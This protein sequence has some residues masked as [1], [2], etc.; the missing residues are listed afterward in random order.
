MPER[1][2]INIEVNSDVATIEATRQALRRLRDEEE[3]LNNERERGRNQQRQ[4]TRQT[5]R[6]TGQQNALSNALRRQSRNANQLR[7]RYAGLMKETFALRKDIGSLIQAFGGFIR[8]MNK[9]SLLEIPLLAVG[10]A[11]ISLLFQ[12]GPGF[13]KLYKSAM[14]GLAYT[15]AG[16]GVIITTLVAAM[17]EFQ[18]VQFAPMYVEGAGNT[19]DR[20]VAAS[21]AMDMFAA[22]TTL[23]VV[24][25][26]S[27]QKAFGTLSKQ[28]AITGSTVAA[29]EGLMNV[30]AGSGGDIGKGS[31]KLATF[32]AKVQKDGLGG[33]G[34]AA[35]E[36]GPDFQKIIKEAQGLG[37]KTSDEFFKA[38]AEGTLGETFQKKYAG[39]LDAL[40][41]TLMGRFKSGMVEIKRILGDLGTR[42]LQPAGESFER[43]RNQLEL[44]IIR[45]SPLLNQFSTGFFADAENIFEKTTNKLVTLVNKYLNTTPTFIEQMK[46]IIESTAEFGDGLQDWA[47]QFEP[48]GKA[49]ID[50]FFSP[51]WD[52]LT[53]KFEGGV[54][55]LSELVL[56]NKPALNAFAEEVVGLIGVLGD[57]ANMLKEAFFAAMPILGVALRTV[58]MIFDVFTKL[59]KGFMKIGEFMGGNMGKGIAAIIA[60]YA[61]L[62]LFSRFFSTLG[63]MFGKDMMIKANH[64][65]INGA[66]MGGMGMGGPVG[67]PGG[68]LTSGQMSGAGY[69]TARQQMQSMGRNAMGAGRNFINSPMSSMAIAGA[70]QMANMAG[71]NM[72]GQGGTAL[73]T[74]GNV[75]T[76]AGM[77][78]MMGMSGRATGALAVVPAAYGAAKM[79]G[80]FIQDMPG[81]KK[82][83]FGK[84]DALGK[85]GMAAAGAGTGAATGAAIGAA[86]APFTAGISVAAFATIGAVVGGITGYINAGK[87]QKEARNAAKGMMETYTSGIEE[88]FLG[89][90]VEDLEKVRKEM[91][92]TNELNLK[93]LA[94][95]GT[96]AK[97][98]EKN[99]TKLRA[100]DKE[101]RVYTSNTALAERATGTGAEELNRLAEAAGVNV[102]DKMLTLVDV[103]K[104]V[105][106]TAT[107]QAALMKQAWA[108]IS[109]IALG[110]ALDYFETQQQRRD[111]AVAAASSEDALRSGLV[112]D[113]TIDKFLKDTLAFG[114]AE[115]GEF[116][117]LGFAVRGVEKSLTEGRLSTLSEDQKELVRTRSTSAFGNDAVMRYISTDP[118][119]KQQLLDM[120]RSG[121]GM[122]MKSDEDLMNLIKARIAEGGDGS[123]AFLLQNLQNAST[124]VNEIGKLI[125]GDKG[126]TDYNDRGNKYLDPS[127]DP[128]IPKPAITTNNNTLNI[129]GILDQRVVDRIV[130]ELNRLNISNR[131]RGAVPVKS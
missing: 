105:G 66:P 55:T 92:E 118:D 51:V 120:A 123:A 18:S 82:G 47:R 113:E 52:G 11:S 67:G 39:Q 78:R 102:R 14:Q 59:M 54:N 91:M 84:D 37:I 75:A 62:T 61:S 71:N 119:A 64:V 125:M 88:A 19:A 53:D 45:L 130:E 104:L 85:A 7:G 48:A 60:I 31:E 34:D 79:T 87:Y 3:E 4:T 63:K 33:A 9:L 108:N 42:F 128:R 112:N 98:M 22:N 21:Q 83:T 100:L 5:R 23:A 73:S 27:L 49:L 28:K 20:F 8:I 127:Q 110:G 56:A 29:F 50:N 74:A 77:G 96:Y 32:L 24:G 13:I 70:G 106:T 93:N 46:S 65:S 101:I 80:N 38:A 17:Q 81:F 86:L 95:Q 117:G 44:T 103:I 43:I 30:V 109:R 25:A 15:A 1:V 16:T 58:T 131:E 26:E 6:N 114:T 76:V 40:N 90:N 124:D 36:L 94:D 69:M 41:S 10:L 2:V 111:S 121:T 35:K 129:S 122:G 68:G 107:Q 97:E 57:Y 72:G 116:G 89:G 126:Y 12:M 115:A 99:G